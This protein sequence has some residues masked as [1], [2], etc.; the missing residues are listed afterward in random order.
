[1]IPCDEVTGRTGKMSN[2]KFEIGELTDIEEIK[3]LNS[4]KESRV[5][6]C[7]RL[8]IK[9][10]TVSPESGFR[11]EDIRDFRQ[12]VYLYAPFFDACGLPYIADEAEAAVKPDLPLNSTEEKWVE[13][14]VRSVIRGRILSETDIENVKDEK[15]YIGNVNFDYWKNLKSDVEVIAKW[16]RSMPESCYSDLHQCV[17]CALA[18]GNHLA[19]AKYFTEKA[20]PRKEIAAAVLE[21]YLDRYSKKDEW[22][23]WKILPSAIWRSLDFE[24]TENNL[25]WNAYDYAQ[26]SKWIKRAGS[27]PDKDILVQLALSMGLDGD[28]TDMLLMASGYDRLYLLDAADLFAK[29][30]LDKY[31][32]DTVTSDYDKRKEVFEQQK[33]FMASQTDLELKYILNEL[34]PE[35]RSDFENHFLSALEEKECAGEFRMEKNA[36]KEILIDLDA[37]KWYVT[38]KKGKTGHIKY[39]DITKV[40]KDDTHRYW[41]IQKQSDSS[42]IIV[43]RYEYVPIARYKQKPSQTDSELSVLSV[44]SSVTSGLHFVKDYGDRKIKYNLNELEPERRSDFEK[45]FLTALQEKVCAGEFK[46]RKDIVLSILGEIDKWD[47]TEKKDKNGNVKYIDI[48]EKENH[49][50]TYWRIQKQSDSSEI[51]VWRYENVS[52]ARY[53]EKLSWNIEDVIGNFIKKFEATSG[54]KKIQKTEY[55]TNLMGKWYEDKK[56]AVT[57]NGSISIS[58]PSESNVE[59]EKLIE[60]RRYGYLKK[61]DNFLKDREAYEKYLP[62][63]PNSCEWKWE[64]SGNVSDLV[65]HIDNCGRLLSK[66]GRKSGYRTGNG[67]NQ[68]TTIWN[69]RSKLFDPYDLPNASA[70]RSTLRN[71]LFGRGDKNK[72]DVIT[73][74]DKADFLK[75]LVITGHEDY[76]G[77]YMKKLGFWKENLYLKKKKTELHI[78]PEDFNMESCDYICDRKDLLLLYA[79]EYRDELLD[80]YFFSGKTDEERNKLKQKFPFLEVVMEI[81]NTIL[82]SYYLQRRNPVASFHEPWILRGAGIDGIVYSDDIMFFEEK[83]KRVRSAENERER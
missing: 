39:I 66:D 56:V 6:R 17:Q 33:K 38:E 69:R 54:E 16:N 26:M 31:G 73:Q 63:D 74:I 25:K 80:S 7:Y 68:A 59:P 76:I 48:E 4:E 65:S 15:L 8:T 67:L 27:I 28:E 46:L 10:L 44:D 13:L 75:F 19:F 23:Q 51:D 9:F 72:F 43:W 37:E 12:K 5:S 49:T 36:V 82:R 57:E 21:K 32:S 24:Y 29:I 52:I 42:E 22:K 18:T 41:G 64:W 55:L 45:D 11:V 2:V 47:V 3:E 14:K 20:K 61:M 77:I 30:A 62:D 53:K 71:M 83:G 81:S 34:E 58:L 1:M 78:E 79:L 60:Q 40:K 70:R 50:H 35:Q